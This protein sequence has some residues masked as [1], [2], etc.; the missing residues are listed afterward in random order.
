MAAPTLTNITIAGAYGDSEVRVDDPVTL[1]M[2]VSQV[3]DAST[4]VRV[5]V[6]WSDGSAVERYQVMP[7]H[8]LRL[9]HG[10]TNP[11]TYQVKLSAVNATESSQYTADIE[12]LPQAERQKTIRRWAG[13]MIGSDSIQYEYEA[14]RSYVPETFSLVSQAVLGANI[15]KIAQ[16]YFQAGDE[17]IVSQS[18]K[19]LSFASV[20]STDD[21]GKIAYLNFPLGA[22]YNPGAEVE[23]RRKERAREVQSYQTGGSIKAGYDTSLIKASVLNLLTTRRGERVMYP[24]IGGRHHELPFEPLDAV[25]ETLFK[26]YTADVIELEPRTVPEQITLQ[27][28]ANEGELRMSISLGFADNVQ[29][30]L[31][32][33]L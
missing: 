16:P 28:S 29:S 20:L 32:V 7:G 30:V 27:K 13:P 8:S 11:G 14:V 10:F 15:I 6:N 23:V 21:E 26:G 1:R 3:G 19:L 9:T 4:S 5:L 18:G 2:E 31:E 25:T 22:T 12:I 17:V 24:N 33:T